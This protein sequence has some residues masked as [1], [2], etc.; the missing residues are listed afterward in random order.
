MASAIPYP[1]P[2]TPCCR[3]RSRYADVRELPLTGEM[4]CRC[5]VVTY[6]RG[7]EG[8]SLRWVLFGETAL[9]PTP[10]YDALHI[11]AIVNHAHHDARCFSM[12]R[13]EAAPSKGNTMSTVTTAETLRDPQDP[14][15]D[16]ADKDQAKK[17]RAALNKVKLRSF[18]A[19]PTSVHAFG[20]STLQW[21]V[22]IP[23]S[24]DPLIQIGVFLDDVA[25]SAT[26]STTVSPSVTKTFHLA[27]AGELVK[28]ELGTVQ[29]A[30]DF[31]T[32][33]VQD[34][35][36]GVLGALM[37]TQIDNTFSGS[38]DLKLKDGGATV[39]LGNFSVNIS[40]PL[41]IEVPDWFNADMDIA[42]KFSLFA[43]DRD[44][45]PGVNVRVLASLDDASV[46]VSWSI[47]SHLLSLGCTGV[48]QEALSKQAEVFLN[49]LMGPGM[50]D[51]LRL[52]VQSDVDTRLAALNA[53]HPPHPFRLHSMTVS[54]VGIS[55]RFCPAP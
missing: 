52:A 49:N 7:A 41:E 24:G 12:R 46:D 27:A 54:D 21:D 50:A 10:K 47:L 39:A 28:R 22:S 16:P 8:M 5:V 4:E 6:R 15:D 14:A 44:P 25:V 1:Y 26:G 11:R 2:S 43:A 19:T 20:K 42:L 31:G 3:S 48:V 29:V 38:P 30:V 32:C 13:L 36:A 17:E 33:Q 37:K 45:G 35:A 53:N 9:R 55:Y 23:P 51:Q 34:L 40:I 18:T